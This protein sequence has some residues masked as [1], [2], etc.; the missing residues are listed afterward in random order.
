MPLDPD[1]TST[2]QIYLNVGVLLVQE[3]D[4]TST[5][6]VYENVGFLLTSDP[7]SVGYVYEGDVSTNPPTPVVWFLKPN[8]GREGDGFEI[9]GWGF[10]TTSTEY[11]ASV[12]I[13]LTPGTWT[14]LPIINFQVISATSNAYN[15]NRVLNEVTGVI[16]PQHAQIA[17][18]IPPGT[19]PPGYP[20][21]V[22]TVTP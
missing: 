17:V 11:S 14:T 16:D 19:E 10:G 3:R 5:E 15:S 21:R 12:Q 13:E 2:E 6:Q 7:D 18:V 9:V 1:V 8:Y 20:V 22:R 4:V